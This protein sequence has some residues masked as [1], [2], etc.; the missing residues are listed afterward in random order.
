MKMPYKYV[1]ADKAPAKPVKYQASKSSE[2]FREIILGL[3]L[4]KVAAITPDENQSQRGIKISVG[5]AA[6]SLDKKVTSW[7][8]EGDPDVYVALNNNQATESA[9]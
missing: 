8:I 5:R 6:S 3:E 7:S 9:E 2:Y 4:G 1:E